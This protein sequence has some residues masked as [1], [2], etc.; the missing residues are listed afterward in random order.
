M[1]PRRLALATRNA[2]K[3]AEIRALL[4]GLPV[5]IVAPERLPEVVED[6]DTFRGNA[7]KKARA[8]AAA[9][10]I[11]A[12]ADDSG[13]EVDALGGAPGVR[14][15]RYAG[16]GATDAA[17]NGKLLDAL[18]G[19]APERRRA[20]FRCLAVVAAPDGSLLAI[21]EGT[22]EGRILEAPRGTSGFGYDPLFL[23][24]DLAVTFA[25]AG[26][27]AKNR[28]SHRARALAA[29]RRALWP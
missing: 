13:L 3:I 20:R 19:V 8:A 11:P 17:N 25:E 15:A 10:G 4:A 24:D 6:A 7:E 12:L 28:V 5:K 21:G 16:P 22:A 23:S 14:S 26:P 9:L 2:G 18:R 29:I 1:P 27:E